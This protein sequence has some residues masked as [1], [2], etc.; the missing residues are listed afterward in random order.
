MQKWVR[1]HMILSC[2]LC[3][4]TAEWFLND[5]D[6]F[7]TMLSHVQFWQFWQQRR[8]C[9]CG[10]QAKECLLIWQCQLEWLQQ[11]TC[12][13]LVHPLHLLHPPPVILMELPKRGGVM[14]GIG[15]DY[16]PPPPPPLG[17]WYNYTD[18]DESDGPQRPNKLVP[19][20]QGSIIKNLFFFQMYFLNIILI[21][22]YT[23][24]SC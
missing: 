18:Y 14:N 1:Q 6:I 3:I 7:N 24:T 15:D 9:W 22:S 17:K 4:H 2:F 23:S 20:Q 12:D 21:M 5:I 11:W 13:N 16:V 8:N 19:Q 10:R